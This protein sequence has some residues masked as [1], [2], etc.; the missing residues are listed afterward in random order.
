[1]PG[2]VDRDSLAVSEVD[3]SKV[4]VGFAADGFSGKRLETVTGILFLLSVNE[5]PSSWS[6]TT[7]SF[8]SLLDSIYD[9]STQVKRGLWV[10]ELCLLLS[11]IVM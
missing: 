11:G 9:F 6:Y 5:V 3:P 4:R 2:E 8:R 7:V 1:M 10:C